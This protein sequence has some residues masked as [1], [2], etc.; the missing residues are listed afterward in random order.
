MIYVVMAYT[1]KSRRSY[2]G[3]R[4]ACSYAC[5]RTCLHTRTSMRM[6][7]HN[8]QLYP[9]APSRIKPWRP[10]AYSYGLYGYGICSYGLYT[11]GIAPWW[12]AE[13]ARSAWCTYVFFAA[14]SWIAPG[15]H[16]RT[17]MPARM[18]M[19]ASVRTHVY[20]RVNEAALCIAPW[21]PVEWAD[22]I[23]LA[24]MLSMLF[25]SALIHLPIKTWPVWS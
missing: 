14:I 23:A 12:P 2:A 10:A 18:A 13:C 3:H 11:H 15:T 4:S 21:W 16:V 8:V 6:H 22:A 24:L 1:Q 5:L 25:S 20:S 19:R 9:K 17:C 7:I